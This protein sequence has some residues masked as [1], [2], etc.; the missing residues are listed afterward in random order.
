MTTVLVYGSSGYVGGFLV[1][2]LAR[3]G[4]EVIRVTRGAST[5][6]TDG[7]AVVRDAELDGLRRERV[8]VVNLAYPRTAGGLEIRAANEALLGRLTRAVERTGAVRMIHAS[9]QAVFGYEWRRAP[10]VG[11]APFLPGDPYIESKRHA[12]Y[13]LRRHWRSR[14]GRHDLAIVRL[15]NVLG[16]GAIPWVSAT[17][18]RILEG[19]PAASGGGRGRLNGT[20]VRNIADYFAFLTELDEPVGTRQPGVYHHLAE[21]AERSWADLIEPM[22]D[23][24]GV[25][26]RY[27]ADVPSAPGVTPR[28]LIGSAV[29]R[30]GS[31]LTERPRLLAEVYRLRPAPPLALRGEPVEDDGWHVITGGGIALPAALSPEWRPPH[32]WDAMLAEIV[33]WLRAHGLTLHADLP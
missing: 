29:R 33:D 28:T 18:Q 11:R 22:A 20:H 4:H 21:F 8:V 25:R 3:R 16:P 31:I 17:A 32:S 13:A 7:A 14:G 2:E 19:R 1:A 6:S 9:S 27:R 10:R 24:I 23:A 12:E 26:P 5:S 15:G 30:F